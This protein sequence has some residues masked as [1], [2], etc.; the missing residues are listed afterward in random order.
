EVYARVL[1]RAPRNQELRARYAST[2]INAGGRDN[3]TKARDLLNELL[4]SRPNDSSRILYLLSQTERRLGDSKAAE[5]TARRGVAQSA[6]RPWGYY[7]L[8]EALE[9]PRDHNPAVSELA[10]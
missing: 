8:A 1:Q 2:L 3:L 10:T 7:A 5:A 6:K 9:G 4:T